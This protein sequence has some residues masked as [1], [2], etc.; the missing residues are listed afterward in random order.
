MIVWEIVSDNGDWN[1]RA[2]L[3]AEGWEPF[4]VGV[5][6]ESIDGGEWIETFFRRHKPQEP[7]AQETGR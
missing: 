1:R 5:H 3:L 2:E 7:A 4:S 6:P